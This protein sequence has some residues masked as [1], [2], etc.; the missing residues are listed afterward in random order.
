MSQNRLQKY[1]LFVQHDIK[2]L[3]QFIQ[4][5]ADQVRE[6]E[7]EDDKKLLVDHLKKVLPIVTERAEK[8]IKQMTLSSG[9][10]QSVE[11][12]EFANEIA[13]IAQGLGIKY[14]LHGV[15]CCSM[16]YTLFEQVIQNVLE[17]FQ[18]HAYGKPLLIDVMPDGHVIFS[19]AHQAGQDD[20]QS[21]RL[22][23][24]FWSSSEE[25]MGL[26]LFIT[27]ELLSTVGGAIYFEALEHQNRFV[28]QFCAQ[29][30]PE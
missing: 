4:L 26:G 8:T 9:S 3:A 7:S 30:S 29:L 2:N 17:N 10:F 27:R 14:Q 11:P 21:E 15:Y 25:G 5:L 13:R 20:I 16:S 19:I 22:F 28:V 12:I 23:E 18:H 24:P 6:A 1:Q